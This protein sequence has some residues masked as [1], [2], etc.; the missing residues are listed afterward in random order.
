MKFIITFVSFC[1]ISISGNAQSKHSINKIWSAESGLK[2]PESVIYSKECDCLIVSCINGVPTNKKDG[3]GYLSKVSLDGKIIEEKWVDNLDAPKGSGISNGVLYV[4]DID[5]IVKIAIKSGKVLGTIPIPGTTFINDVFVDKKGTIYFTDSD[6]SK[7]F[8]YKKGKITELFQ[9]D[10]LARINGVFKMG[11]N[12]YFNSSKSGN[13]ASFNLKS[14]QLNIFGKD[15]FTGDGIK[16]FKNGFLISA[17]NGELYHLVPE[18]EKVLLLDTKAAKKNAA[19]FEF[20][21]SKNMII[22][23]TFNGNSLD[24][25]LIK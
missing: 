24:A 23:P 1:L 19:D 14:N 18:K 5:K 7:A 9:S 21:A 16:P 12:L 13:V 20:L 6:Q 2:T 22:I 4:A 25:Y 10:D 15:I 8:K 17:W 11:N 3:D